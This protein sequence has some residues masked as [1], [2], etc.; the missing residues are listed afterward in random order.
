MIEAA[1]SIEAYTARG[2]DIFDSDSAVQEAILYQIIVLG[3]AAKGVVKADAGVADELSTVEWS[4][5]AR[6]RDRVAHRYWETDHEIV[7]ATATRDIPEL[8]A[9]LSAAIQRLS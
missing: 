2:R 9:T 5:L 4:L 6:M 7:W 1:N 8:R 3:E